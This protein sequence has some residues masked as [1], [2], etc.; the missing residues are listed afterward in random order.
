VDMQIGVCHFSYGENVT[1]GNYTG[2]FKTL[3]HYLRRFV[4]GI[5][6]NVKYEHKFS[7]ILHLFRVTASLRYVALINMTDFYFTKL[8]QYILTYGNM[9][10]Y[11]LFTMK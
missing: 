2:R 5:I 10:S 11:F 3:V 9:F 6:W 8:K 4:E 7:F 1:G